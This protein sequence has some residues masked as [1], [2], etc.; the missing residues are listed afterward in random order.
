MYTVIE[1]PTF[2]QQSKAIWTDSVRDE[3]FDWIARNPLAGAD[4]DSHQV[5]T[6]QYENQCNQK[7]TINMN[8]LKNIDIEAVA[9]AI[10]MDAGHPLAGLRESL[11]QAQRGE[12]AAVH[13]PAQITARRRG[14]PV[15]SVK[16]APKIQTAIRFDPDVLAALKATG[17][18]WQTRVNEAMREWLKNIPHPMPLATSSTPESHR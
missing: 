15:G 17:K 11:G 16:A 12:Y 8:H 4:C 9:R 6:E 2:Q 7:G 5:G 14:R 3:F 18:G 13:T 10:E 1:T